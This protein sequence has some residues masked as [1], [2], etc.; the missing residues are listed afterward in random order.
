VSAPLRVEISDLAMA[1]VR[2]AEEWWRQNRPKAPNAVREEVERAAVLLSLQP[3]SGALA[4]NVSLA[5]VRRIHL[6]RIRYY[7]F[8]RVVPDPNTIEILALWHS[9]RQGSPTL[10]R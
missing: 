7:L 5:G 4:R 1:Q 10:R 6:T 2:A 9:S 3:E 8:Y